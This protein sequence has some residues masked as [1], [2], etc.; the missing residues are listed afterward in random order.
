[1]EG[2][3]G[4]GSCELQKRRKKL[5]SWR[6]RGPTKGLQGAPQEM[7]G[8]RWVE[9]GGWPRNKW[10]WV[11]KSW[12]QHATFAGKPS[13]FWIKLFSIWYFKIR[14]VRREAAAATAGF[15]GNQTPSAASKRFCSAD[16]K[17]PAR[18]NNWWD[19]SETSSA[20]LVSF[21]SRQSGLH[22]FDESGYTLALKSQYVRFLFFFL[23]FNTMSQSINR[24]TTAGGW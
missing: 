17:W 13:N 5:N 9:K 10:G 15:E 21:G 16:T 2:G 1:M 24:P 11:K 19:Q 18:P 23:F 6:K 14:A 4:R 12:I 22:C 20:C 3:G 8:D 7:G